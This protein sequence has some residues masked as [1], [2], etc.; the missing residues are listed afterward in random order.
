M[1]HLVIL[2]VLSLSATAFADKI[3]D[4]SARINHATDVLNKAVAQ[5]DM[6]IPTNLL[7]QATCVA[8]FPEIVKAGF[9]VGAR[10][11]DGVVSCRTGAGW[12]EPSFV[13]ISGGSFG[14]QIGVQVSELI[15]V[16]VEPD[17]MKRF[18][19]NTVTLGGDLSVAA[20]PVG[21][22][23]AAAVDT[24]NGTGVYAYSRN[25]GLFAGVSLDGSVM[26]IE[27][28]DNDIAYGQRMGHSAILSSPLTNPTFIVK[29]FVD[30][31]NTIAP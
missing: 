4:L 2:L 13:S 6:S 25:K 17:A 10:H 21:R 14:F 24:K 18:D 22:D 28:S 23:A 30:T 26:T 5:P 16:F 11:G 1:R 15:L 9:I 8:V 3:G 12:S 7:K 27:D 31:L 20:G 19:Q 29:P